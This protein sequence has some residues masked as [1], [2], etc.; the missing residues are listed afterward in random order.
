[1]ASRAS[2]YRLPAKSPPA[3]LNLAPIVIFRQWPCRSSPV[4]CRLLLRCR[5]PP[6]RD[7]GAHADR[8]PAS[9]CYARQNVPQYGALFSGG[10]LL[11]PPDDARSLLASLRHCW[12]RLSVSQWMTTIVG[13][14]ADTQPLHCRLQIAVA[15]RHA[16]LT[17]A[18]MTWRPRP[19]KRSAMARRR[20]SDRLPWAAKA[21]TSS[22][23]TIN[24]CR[25]P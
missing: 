1:M 14:G 23:C 5:E 8:R 20:A 7:V 15:C 22:V 16:H 2:S 11:L 3:R 6:R 18:F 12:S 4:N 25:L 10:S 9:C 21:C 19:M 17:A 24:W 13:I